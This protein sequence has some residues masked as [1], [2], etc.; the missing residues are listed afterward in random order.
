[1]IAAAPASLSA[2]G[3]DVEGNGEQIAYNAGGGDMSLDNGVLKQDAVASVHVQADAGITA[4]GSSLILAGNG[5]TRT[6]PS[7]LQNGGGIQMNASIDRGSATWAA[8]ASF[9]ADNAQ[10]YISPARY[11]GLNSNNPVSTSFDTLGALGYYG[12]VV[13]ATLANGATKT[14]PIGAGVAHVAQAAAGDAAILTLAAGTAILSG[15]INGTFVA[16]SAPASGKIGFYWD[17]AGSPAPGRYTIKNNLGSTAQ[18]FFKYDMLR[19]QP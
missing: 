14:F 11:Y 8:V 10:N 18:L 7:V 2:S 19:N 15:D 12:D 17:A 13:Q 6:Q 1:L 5:G 16:S 4:L 3:I 9:T